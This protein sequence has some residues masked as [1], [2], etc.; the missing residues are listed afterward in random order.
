ME[1]GGNETSPKSPLSNKRKEQKTMYD[2]IVKKLLEMAAQMTP[3]QKKEFLTAA[4]ELLLLPKDSLF[5]L[6]SQLQ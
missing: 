6:E 5:V 2:A 1:N 3:E 4:K